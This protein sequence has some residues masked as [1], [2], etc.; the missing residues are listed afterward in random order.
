MSPIN[1][2]QAANFQLPRLAADSFSSLTKQPIVFVFAG[3]HDYFFSNPDLTL[4]D[5]CG[6]QVQVIDDIVGRRGR[7]DGDGVVV[8]FIFQNLDFA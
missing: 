1:S 4:F 3:F 5:A 7:D 6:K 2:T 8:Y